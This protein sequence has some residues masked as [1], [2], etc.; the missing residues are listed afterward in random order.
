LCASG[1][2]GQS[3]PCERETSNNEHTGSFLGTQSSS[4]MI[5]VGPFVHF[6]PFFIENL[7]NH[8]ISLVKM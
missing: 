4:N 3:G 1:D 7:V 8:L 6:A 5:K 2:D